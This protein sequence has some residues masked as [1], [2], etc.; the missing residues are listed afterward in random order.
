MDAKI[1]NNRLASYAAIVFLALIT[2]CAVVSP[3]VTAES[4]VGKTPVGP[5]SAASCP[6]QDFVTFLQL[7]ADSEDDSVRRFFTGDPL[8]YEVPFHTV[9]DETSTSPA[10]HVSEKSGIAR[11]EYFFYR[12][13]KKSRAFNRLDAG[14]DLAAVEPSKTETQKY[15]ISITAEPNGGRKVV[16]GLEYEV[17]V[18]KF[19]RADNCWYM[20]RAINPRD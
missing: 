7:Y 14:N 2:G 19:K 20:T 3:A 5:W 4:K 1:K 17:D 9:Q 15:P 12:Y 10:M 6:S 11:L 16:F 8:E 13:S 18:Y